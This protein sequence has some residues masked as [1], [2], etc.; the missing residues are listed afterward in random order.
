MFQSTFINFS[1]GSLGGKSTPAQL[2]QVQQEIGEMLDKRVQID[3]VYLD[4]AK[5]FDRVDHRLM[6]NKFKNFGISRTLLNLFEDYLSKRHQ[7]VWR[8]TGFNTWTFLVSSLR[9][10]PSSSSISIFYC[11]VR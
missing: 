10:R 6:V 4:F 8:T 3:F 11:N 7:R 2:L 5:A 1:L 9:E